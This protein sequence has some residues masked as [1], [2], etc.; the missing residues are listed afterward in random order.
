MS[1]VGH[2]K[3]GICETVRNAA[4][5]VKLLISDIIFVNYPGVHEGACGRVTTITA[6]STRV[7]S[8]ILSD[9]RP[10]F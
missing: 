1:L 5:S 4:N 9:S 2:T 3:V 6:E 10:M 7:A 8:A